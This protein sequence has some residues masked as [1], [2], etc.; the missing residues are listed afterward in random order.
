MLGELDG[1]AKEVDDDLTNPGGIPYHAFGH[2]RL[3]ITDQF[4]TLFVGTEGKRLGGLFEITSKVERDH[5]KL[6]P[7]GFYFGKVEDI[8]DDEKQIVCR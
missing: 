5:L 7:A 8:V 4:Q 1:I 3:D 2:V 6:Q